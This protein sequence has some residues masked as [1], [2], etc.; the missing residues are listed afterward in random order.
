M[1]SDQEYQAAVERQAELF[2][3]ESKQIE[4]KQQEEK[5]RF[6]NE[7]ETGPNNF[8]PKIGQER[9]PQPGKIQKKGLKAGN[10]LEIKK[11]EGELE[12]RPPKVPLGNNDGNKAKDRKKWENVH[13]G[14]KNRMANPHFNFKN[15]HHNQNKGLMRNQLDPPQIKEIPMKENIIHSNSQSS[16][17]SASL[18]VFIHPSIQSFL[19][20]LTLLK[21][22]RDQYQLEEAAR[23]QEKS[24]SI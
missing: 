24:N 1:K 21:E 17:S 5:K 18:N 4:N 23:S 8:K 15:N 6:H 13:N 3:K 10:D 20:I 7:V 9:V 16:S 22:E 19:F 12:A 2:R 14:Q 11:K